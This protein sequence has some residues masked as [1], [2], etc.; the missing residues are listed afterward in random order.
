MRLRPSASD[1]SSSRNTSSARAPPVLQ[2]GDQADAVSARDLLAGQVEHMAKQA[3]DRRAEHV[4]DV[5]GR[6]CAA[7][8]P[9][10]SRKTDPNRGADG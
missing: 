7:N 4:Q 10:A 9:A 1:G 6:H 2:V 5:Q 3:A 8:R